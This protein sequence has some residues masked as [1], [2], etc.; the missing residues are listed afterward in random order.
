[1]DFTLDINRDGEIRILQLSDPQIMY[2][3]NDKETDREKN[4]YRYIRELVAK[5][6]PDLIVLAGDIVYG[7]FDKGGAAQK[8]INAL[9]D[10]FG[11]PWAPVYGNHDYES[12]M[13]QEW[14][15]EQYRQAKYALYTKGDVL[16]DSNYTIGIR[17]N[18]AYIRELCIID[19]GAWTRLKLELQEETKD[20]I[21]RNAG[22]AGLPTFLFYHI[23]TKD[24]EQAAIEAGYMTEE[25]PHFEI[26]VTVPAKNGDFGRKKEGYDGRDVCLLPQMKACHVDGVFAAHSHIL[27]TSILWQGIRFTLG[28]KTG[29]YDYHD[30]DALGGTLIRLNGREFTVEHQYC[31]KR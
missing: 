29:T 4:A 19:S 30:K 2:Y 8:E 1:M 22:E 18:G 15:N 26:G 28:L 27:N 24:F 13:G 21:L 5:T 16:G 7:M 14:L 25:N 12:D 31:E 9:M 20:W 23:P 17:Q 10:S 3:V 6:D 11:I